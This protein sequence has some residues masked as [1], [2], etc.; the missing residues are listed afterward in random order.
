MRWTIIVAMGAA[1]ICAATGAETADARL[2]I[3]V[4]SGRADLVTS[5]DALVRVAL[6]AGVA[7]KAVR[8]TVDHRD[9][10]G[11]FVPR[12]RAL[13][14]R[15]SRLRPG[16]N[17]LVASR[18]DGSG[19]QMTLV[20][21]PHGGPLFAGKQV[22]PWRCNPGALDAHCNREPTYSFLYMPAL[23]SSVPDPLI[24][25]PGADPRFLP[26]ALDHPPPAASVAQTTTD[27]GR[28]VPLIVRVET[29]AIDRGQY[30]I[31]TLY[32]PDQQK[33]PGSPPTNWDHKLLLLGGPN[34]GITY[35][36]GTAPDVLAAR[37]LR[38]GF[39]VMSTA[40][41][42]TGSDCNLVLQAES[43]VMAKAYLI[44]HY[45]PVRYT[46]G[47]GGSGA[48]IVQQWNANA[49]PGIYDGLI[50]EAS[51]PDAWTQLK[52][53][54]DCVNLL[55]YW[56]DPSQWGAGVAWTPADQGS[57]EGG[58]LP[59]SCVLW[60][61]GF[62]GNFTPA[63]ETAQLAP[64]GVY[65]PKANPCGVRSD[66]WDYSVSQLGRRPSTVWSAPEK[67]CGTGF[68]KR[69][70]D[71]VGVQYGLNALRAGQITPAQFA[72]L[73]AKVGGRD[74]DYTWQPSR[75]R[76]D[77]G[78]LAT[79]YRSGYINQANHVDVPII[80]LRSV[81]NAE[82]HDTYNS[83]VMRARLDRARGDHANQVIWTA[84]E[85]SG[86]VIDPVQEALAFDLM[87]RWLD[88]IE[89]D[90]TDRA[91]A[92]KV[93]ANKPAEAVDRCT[94][95]ANLQVACVYPPSGSPRLG[96]GE[97]LT[98]DIPG[99]RRKPLDRAEYLPARLSDDEWTALQATFPTG[100]CDYSKPG[101]GQQPTVPWLTYKH[102]PGGEPLGA[103]PASRA[104]TAHIRL[105][106][107]KRCVRT[108]RLR[109]RLKPSR[110]LRLRSARVFVNGK[111]ARIL[112]GPRLTKAIGLR[113]GTHRLIRVRVVAVTVAR[114]RVTATRTYRRCRHR[115][116]S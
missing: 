113:V 100:V 112:S 31:A 96:A 21:H 85:L 61:A 25:G 79:L 63:D 94:L 83:F 59:T 13:V 32:D 8:V 1:A 110:G 50:V 9:V 80:D 23:A 87:N 103:P 6:P 2:R 69:P 27:D 39:A 3:A 66:L 89:A 72:D 82:I 97:P 78:V 11:A 116:G 52:K 5:G 68:A 56:N 57:V 104:F 4:L 108:G 24:G 71:N 43:I 46:L 111:R 12:G 76:A 88:A 40:L 75:T 37:A 77:R 101:R 26:Y 44:S 49:Y 86:F 7:P 90:R 45:G 107:P 19:A 33:E 106:S 109:L 58:D 55:R 64:E 84:Q 81:S 53:A 38:R 42:A 16:R 62:E 30:K 34:C 105:A 36:E 51:F 22:Q 20:N 95:V 54:D 92:Q 74:I 93:V 35:S 14:G 15:V 98:D 10:T 41:M 17:V 70:L 47:V 18:P 65:E 28:T 29:G 114:G 102:G 91:L 115:S 67:T 73:N 99:C 60:K 48:S